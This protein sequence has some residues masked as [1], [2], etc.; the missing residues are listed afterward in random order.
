MEA[1]EL[2]QRGTELLLAKDMDAFTDLFAPDC[3]VEFPFAEVTPAR[4]TG[5]EEVRAYLADYPERMDITGFPSVLV[6]RTTD[7]STLV[8]ELTA[9]GRTVATGEAYE[10]RYAWVLVVRDGLVAE[11][12]DYW[13][14]VRA[15]RA[16]G[17][18]RQLAEALTAEARA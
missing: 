9:H 8:V 12:R 15:A 7:P 10:M 4:L 13:S 2:F 6:H 14:P 3:T 16:S 11:L 17:T 1:E 5:R 18:V